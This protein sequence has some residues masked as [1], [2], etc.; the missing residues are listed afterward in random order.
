MSVLPFPEI[1]WQVLK[2][3]LY[4]NA[5]SFVMQMR[6]ALRLTTPQLGTPDHQEDI[7]LAHAFYRAAMHIQI[8]VAPT[9]T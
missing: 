1:T 4:P 5:K 3:N 2:I 8:S 9:D 6:I 7:R